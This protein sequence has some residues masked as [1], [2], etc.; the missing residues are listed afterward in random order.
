M[1]ANQ[2]EFEQGSV[3]KVLLDEKCKPGEIYKRISDVWCVQRLI[4]SQKTIYKWAKQDFIYYELKIHPIF[5]KELPSLFV[6]WVL[7]H[8]NPSRLFNAKSTFM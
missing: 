3:I 7:W 6:C 5:K 4:F 1:V 2:T 8:I